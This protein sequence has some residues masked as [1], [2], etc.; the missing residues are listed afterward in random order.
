MSKSVCLL[1][2][3]NQKLIHRPNSYKDYKPETEALAQD[4]AAPKEGTTKA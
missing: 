3:L 4:E 2:A 1:G